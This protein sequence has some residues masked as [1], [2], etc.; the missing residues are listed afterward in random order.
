MSLSLSVASLRAEI[1][2]IER[3]CARHI[4]WTTTKCGQ[5]NL[6]GPCWHRRRELVTALGEAV[7]L[8]A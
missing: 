5:G 7:M 8:D 1:A 6:C 4:S 2:K 3:G